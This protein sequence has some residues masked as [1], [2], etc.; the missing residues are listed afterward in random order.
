MSEGLKLR[1]LLAELLPEGWDTAA[2]LCAA[3]RAPTLAQRLRGAQQGSD[4]GSA[5]AAGGSG[6]GSDNAKLLRQVPQGK[7]RV[8]LVGFREFIFSD[9][10]GALAE[11][12]AA[13]ER[14]FG[15]TVQR[16]MYN[17]GGFAC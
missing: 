9:D 12:A 4:G 7:G 17:P 11:F 10:S 8:A 6:G 14:S 13:T 2:H 3:N 15:T 1:N 5:A 16:L